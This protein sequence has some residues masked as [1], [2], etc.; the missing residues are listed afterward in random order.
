MALSILTLLLYNRY[1]TDVLTS[2]KVFDGHLLK[3]LALEG[4]GIDLDTEIIAKLSLRHE[5]ILELPVDF[6][7]RTREQGKKIT[8][9]DGFKAMLALFKHRF[10]TAA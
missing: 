3:T 7:A 6:K 9:S 8:P 4:R 2:V 5:Y 10:R 1:V